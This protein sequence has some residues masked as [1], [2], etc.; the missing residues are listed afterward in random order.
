MRH[1]RLEQNG[2]YCKS[3]RRRNHEQYIGPL[4]RQCA[5]RRGKNETPLVQNALQ[6]RYGVRD[7]GIAADNSSLHCAFRSMQTL[8]AVFC[9]NLPFRIVR[10][11]RAHLYIVPRGGKMFRAIRRKSADPG[12]F[13]PIIDA[14][15]QD[16]HRQTFRQVLRAVWPTRADRPVSTKVPAVARLAMAAAHRRA[17][18]AVNTATKPGTDPNCCYGRKADSNTSMYCLATISG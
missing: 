3:Q 1:R 6:R 2:G 11:S 5:N 13:G 9:R 17:L 7:V 15:N 12:N 18:E 10:K 16:S 4:P 8:P 14:Q